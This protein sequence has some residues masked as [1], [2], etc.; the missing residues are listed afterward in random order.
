MFSDE[1]LTAKV[2]VKKINTV[3][4]TLLNEFFVLIYIYTSLNQQSPKPII[5]RQSKLFLPHPKFW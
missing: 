2:E 5:R 4:A 1:P 3:E